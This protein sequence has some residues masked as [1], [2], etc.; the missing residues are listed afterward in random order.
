MAIWSGNKEVT[1][2]STEIKGLSCNEIDFVNNGIRSL[3]EKILFLTLEQVQFNSDDYYSAT[4]SS[5]DRYS[6]FSHGFIYYTAWAMSRKANIKIEKKKLEDGS[7]IF[8][9]E[10]G[11]ES[12]DSD[13]VELDFRQFDMTD[14]LKPYFSLLFNALNGMAKGVTATQGIVFYLEKLAETLSDQKSVEKVE[15]MIAGAVGAVRE[16]KTGYASAGSRLEFISF[17][18]TTTQATVNFCY[19]LISGQVGLPVSAINGKGGSAMSDTGNSDEKAIRRGCEYFF[20][21]I[22]NPVMQSIFI[23]DKFKLKPVLEKLDSLP[24]IASTLEIS[25]LFTDDGKKLILSQ[26]GLSDE[27]INLV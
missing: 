13:I 25:G 15:K 23:G 26:F 9:K 8:K 14:A 11:G 16:G 3:Y 24:A 22:L 12:T 20:V 19:E 5:A 10:T 18:P 7:Y 1:W 4:A 17:D 6:P 21:S 27:D 2:A